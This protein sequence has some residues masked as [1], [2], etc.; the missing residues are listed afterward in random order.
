MTFFLVGI[1][2]CT[3][4]MIQVVIINKYY[5]SVLYFIYVSTIY[6]KESSRL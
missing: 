6:Y 5:I 3:L 1:A 2:M 4:Y